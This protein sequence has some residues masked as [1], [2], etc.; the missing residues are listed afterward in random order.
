MHVEIWWGHLKGRDLL[1]SILSHKRNND[2]KMVFRKI[3]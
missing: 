1:A 2:F 3:G